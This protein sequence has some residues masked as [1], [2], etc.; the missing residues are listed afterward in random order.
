MTLA[1]LVTGGLAALNVFPAT[2]LR[3]VGPPQVGSNVPVTATNLYDKPSNNSPLVAVDPTDERFMVVA[4]RRD[5]PFGC[6]LQASGDAGATWV[7]ARVVPRLPSG[8][9][10]CY[11]PEVVFDG[12]GTLHYLFVGLAGAG[13]SPMGVFLTTSTD[14]ARNFSTPRQILGPDRYMVRMAIDRTLGERGRIHL[15]WL[16]AATDPPLGGFAPPPNPIL[17][18]FSDDGG[19][20]FSSPV[21]VS[22]GHRQRAAAPSLVVGPDH[23]VHV[24]YYD[25]EEDARDYQGLEGPTWEGT[26]SLLLASSSDGGRHFGEGVVVDDNVVPPERVMLIFTMS[27]PSLAVDGEGRVYAA[28]HDARN[29]DWDVF[30]RRS[31]DGRTWTPPLRV[32]DDAVGNDRHQYLPRLAIAPGGRIDAIFYDRR[33]NAENR[34]NDVYYSYSGDRGSSFSPNIRV[35]SLGSDSS[36]GPRYAVPSAQ[37]LIEFGSRIGL[38]SRETSAFAAW[39]DTRYTARGAPAQ[40]IFAARLAFPTRREVPGGMRIAGAAVALA[41]A[42]L[43]AALARRRSSRQPSYKGS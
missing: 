8:A 38:V 13:N 12:E 41:A 9:D 33:G 19:R 10:T 25:L 39:T 30:L 21:Q 18:S 27:P 34:G 5:A 7:T 15:A 40:D 1:G 42:A 31:R 26:W 20:T 37:G 3:A 16:E 17:S 14:R 22:D 32:N 4:N 11:G 43:G 36:I 28:W 24:L 29:G 2:R 35:T 6:D 23:T